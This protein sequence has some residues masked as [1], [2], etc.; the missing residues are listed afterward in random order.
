MFKLSARSLE[1]I[2]KTVPRT[3]KSCFWARFKSGNMNKGST[4]P[5]P[6]KS[7]RGNP[8]LARERLIAI[9][10]IDQRISKITR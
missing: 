8:L 10:E 3:T 1:I 5:H 2:K 6:Q 9:E 4:L 7:G